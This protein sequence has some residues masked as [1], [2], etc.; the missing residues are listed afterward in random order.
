M[1]EFEEY[2]E[3]EKRIILYYMAVYLSYIVIVGGIIVFILLITNF[4][5]L[6]IGG[7]LTAYMSFSLAILMT[8]LHRPIQKF[9]LRKYFAGISV[10]FLISSITMFLQ[11]FGFIG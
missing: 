5:M 2:E 7:I 9:S 10:L 3:E 11:Y 8:F 4:S 1:P 6:L